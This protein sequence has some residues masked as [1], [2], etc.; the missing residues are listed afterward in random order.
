[1]K[2]LKIVIIVFL[3][4]F[5]TWLCVNLW[6]SLSAG[7][8]FARQD[9][10]GQAYSVV[11]EKEV[12]AESV[13]SL[14][15]DYSMTSNDIQIRQ[16]DG[17][18]IRIREYMNYTPQED[19]IS[20]VEQS[21]GRL[22]VK[23]K[24]RFTF[25]LFFMFGSSLEDAYTEICLPAG[26]AER[27]YEFQAKT[28]SGDVVSEIPFATAESFVVSTTSGDLFFPAV[29]A[30]KI[31]VSTTSGNI[32]LTDVSGDCSFSTTSGDILIGQA[33]SAAVFTTTSGNIRVEQAEGGI[34][35]DTTS[36]DIWL[37]KMD[38]DVSVNTTS[39]N[40]RIEAFCGAFRIGTTSGEVFIAGK[41]ES[42]TVS[43]V[44]GD[45]SV[46]A[47]ELGGSLKL[48]TTS[49][50]VSLELPETSSFAL[51]FSSTSG[52]CSTFFD[53]SL[54]FNKKGNKAQG[55]YGDGT[56]AVTVSTVSG[57]LRIARRQQTK[58]NG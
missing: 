42:G 14:L 57:D 48:S 28:V 50:D 9:R 31:R 16:W 20:T 5:M 22:L 37:G 36:G 55:A 15:I 52:E 47:D 54:S 45:I 40:I 43:T 58:N 12:D 19:E 8:G 26:F 39:G 10:S 51:D 46:F 29:R 25:S 1:M 56:Y 32:H 38:G 24:K 30:E 3:G 27:L 23:G 35:A 7:T 34:D 11:L 17:D 13:S 4:L 53:D 41:T 6:F 18:G 33:L 44:S 2:Q 21:D 49:G